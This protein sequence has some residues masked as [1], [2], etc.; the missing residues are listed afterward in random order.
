MAIHSGPD[1]N[2]VPASVNASWYTSS[3]ILFSD[4]NKFPLFT[5]QSFTLLSSAA[6]AMTAPFLE[7]AHAC[8]KPLCPR[9]TRTHEAAST[10]HTHTVQSHEA[11]AN[12]RPSHEKATHLML[13]TCCESFRMLVRIFL[14]TSVVT[15]SGWCGR[16]AAVVNFR[17]F[18]NLAT[19]HL[20]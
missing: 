5:D 8:T 6:D 12:V 16:A 20:L 10:S 1:D 11:L 19:P 4:F 7:N 17:V 2:K 3:A 13:L 14:P 9:N 15:S 18:R